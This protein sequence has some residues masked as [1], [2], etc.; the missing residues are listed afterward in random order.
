[1]AT[2]KRAKPST[3]PRG[4]KQKKKRGP[5]QLEQQEFCGLIH[6]HD[7]GDGP[8]RITAVFVAQSWAGEPHNAEPHKHEGLFWVSLEKPRRTATRTPPPSSTCSPTAPPTGL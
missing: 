8:D 5:R 1:M 4:S 3:T 6:H 2:C 7:P